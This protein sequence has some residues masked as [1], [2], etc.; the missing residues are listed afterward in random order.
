MWM[1]KLSGGNGYRK[2]NGRNTQFIMFIPRRTFGI[3]PQCALR[4]FIP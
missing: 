2:H 1:Y 3:V 4:G